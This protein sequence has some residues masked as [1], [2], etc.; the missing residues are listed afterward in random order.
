MGKQAAQQDQPDN[1]ATNLH[2]GAFAAKTPDRPAIIMGHSGEIITFAQYEALSNQCAHLLRSLG[3]QRGDGMAIFMENNAIYQPMAWGG[4]RAGLRVTTVA[5][6]LSQ[7]EVDYILENSGARVLIT[8]AGMQTTARAL[9]LPGVPRSGRFMFD[10]PADAADRFD[11]L[12]AALS[13]QPD[14]PITDQ[15]EG[16]DMLYSSGTTGR[17]KAVRKPLPEAPFGTPHPSAQLTA[18]L[19]GLGEET[20]YLSP[21]P[22]YHAAPFITNLRVNR[23]G[24]TCVIMEKYDPEKAL[25]LIEQHRVTVSQW[26]PTHFIR[27]LRLPEDVRAKYDTSSLRVAFHAA[28]PCP[29]D[30]K[31]Q[32]IDWWGPVIQEYY[33]GSEGNG[34]CHITTQEWLKKPGSVG[35]AVI[36][37]LRIC[38]DAGHEVPANQEGTIYFEGGPVFEYHGDAE[39]TAA[40]RTPK[41]W[42]TLGDVGYVDD[43][44]YLFL[45]D[46]K[47]YMIISGGVNIYPQESENILVT[48]EAVVDAAVIG[49]PN[50]DFGEEVKA[51]VQ[52]VDPSR[53]G[54]EME[55]EL[56]SYCRDRLS[57]VKCPRSVDFVAQLPREENG[58]LY[59]RKLRDQYW[60]KG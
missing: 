16:V 56:I 9:E 5:T 4:M 51:V 55:K 34:Y 33:A 52:L 49:V 27:M 6:H 60:E 30:V 50:P 35:R 38:D 23:Y 37:R 40:S 24:G 29:A 36:G 14:T 48:H 26:V 17:P 45:T 25:A 46:R 28:A 32:M 8:S 39:K 12:R 59:K 18:K 57:H 10:R 21:A 11:D 54:P 13:A 53:A 44:G 19:Y 31:R 22:L 41:G 15:S 2:V 42:S 1:P 47:A 58:K 20:V 3:L 43:D 7:P